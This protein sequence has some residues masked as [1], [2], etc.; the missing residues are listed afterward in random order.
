M[1]PGCRLNMQL[2]PRCEIWKWPFCG[3]KD[4]VQRDAESRVVV[5]QGVGS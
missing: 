4:V 3:I 1:N 2:A 5:I